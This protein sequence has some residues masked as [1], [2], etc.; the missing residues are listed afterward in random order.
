MTVR[1]EVHT[2]WRLAQAWPRVGRGYYLEAS[3]LDA[4]IQRKKKGLLF[5]ISTV[6]NKNSPMSSLRLGVL[7]SFVLPSLEYSSL[8]LKTE[9]PAFPSLKHFPVFEKKRILDQQ[10]LYRHWQLSFHSTQLLTGS[11]CPGV[12]PARVDAGRWDRYGQL[13]EVRES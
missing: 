5:D 3:L 1:T 11:P 7:F 4:C 13:R 10:S 6:T 8:L 2:S 9:T 12:S